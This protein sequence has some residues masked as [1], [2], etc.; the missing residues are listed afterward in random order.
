MKRHLMR[1]IKKLYRKIEKRMLESSTY[2]VKQ[3]LH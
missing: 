2:L 3:V 1:D